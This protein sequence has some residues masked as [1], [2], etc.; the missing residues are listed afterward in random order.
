MFLSFFTKP[1]ARKKKAVTAAK[2]RKGR[3]QADPE[4]LEQSLDDEDHEIDDG[5]HNHE[6]IES[7]EEDPE[8]ADAMDDELQDADGDTSNGQ[9]TH[10]DGA[11]KTERN[12]AIEEMRRRGVIIDDATQKLAESLLPKVISVQLDL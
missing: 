5:N 4:P 8:L 3:R 12:I 7:N 6:P 1:V 2:S 11:V 10:D 9:V